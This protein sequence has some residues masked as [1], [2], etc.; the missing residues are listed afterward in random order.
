MKRKG[1]WLL[2]TATVAAFAAFI[3]GSA[4][5]TVGASKF[6]GNDGN[7]V[8]NT[9]GNID[10]ANGM[11]NLVVGTDLT[12]SQTDNSF[13]QGTKE[14]NS[15]VTVVA[16]SIPNSKADLARFAIAGEV[17]GNDTYMYLAWSRANQS[18]TV[19]FDFELNKLAQPNLTTPGP[20]TL[21]R[22]V[23][24]LLI[25]YAFAGGSNTPT[26]TKYHWTGSAWQ[27]DGVISSTCSEGATN[28]VAVN[29]T[30]ASPTVSRPAQQF[31]EASINMTCAGIVPSGACE[32][33]GSGYVKSRSST[34]F[35]SEIKDFVAPVPI[36]FSN[37]GKLTIIKHT[38]P[39]GLDQSFGY[40]TTG[41]LSPGTF[42]LNDNGNTT[43]DSTG[44]TQVYS[45]LH[46][47]TY[48]VTEDAD[49]SGFAFNNVSCSGTG[50]SH[51]TVAGRQVSVAI[52][53]GD[54]I[55]CTYVN[56]QQLGAIQVTKESTK[57]GNPPL[58]GATFSVTGPGGFSQT[59]TTD[60]TGTACVEGLT[61][62]D[63]TVTETGAPTGYNLD[64][65]SDHTVTV[66]VNT[67]C[68]GS[69]QDIGGAFL[70]T[71][72]TD[73]SANATSQATGGTASHIVCTDSNGNTVGESASGNTD[74]ADASA[75]GLMPGTYIC[76]IVIDP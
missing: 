62:G 33:F 74:P 35:T 10:W 46:T 31:G 55:T 63:Y 16:G 42:S 13:G 65:P 36:S 37:C 60:S 76:T 25:N 73:I 39:R 19:N 67:D 12:N 44:N 66:N 57:N 30:L 5:A 49:P 52:A 41:G 24:D 9:A 75:T 71:P 20:K 54:D 40:T 32:S 29:D 48:T 21:N 3:V 61:F 64:D 4:S 15:N 38:N 1:R 72:L 17:I 51:A 14:D 22:S 11:P 34:A 56:D 50:S 69:P 47:G 6:E 7:L 68:A 43:G 26:L 58:A 23:N 53:A 28:G 8:V 70:D 18:G 27:N 2:A 59:L 45:A